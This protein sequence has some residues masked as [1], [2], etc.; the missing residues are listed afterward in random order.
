MSKSPIRSC[1]WMLTV[2][3]LCLSGCADPNAQSEQTAN[4]TLTIGSDVYSPYFYLDDNGSFTGVD[5]EIATEACHRLDM[6][7][8][9]KRIDWQDKDDKLSGG[10]V[11]CLW[12]SF[13]MNGREDQYAW[14]G[15]YMYSRQ[16]VAV[17]A[18]S[19]IYAL[20]D[21]TDKRIAV[22]NSSM[23]E[24][25]FISDSIPNVSVRKVYSFT[26][27]STAFA[28]LR[29]GYVDACAAH[30]AALRDEMSHID[31]EYRILD[32]YL[33]K[34]ELGVAF[35]KDTGTE[36]AK[37]LTAV[38]DEMREDGTMKNILENYDLDVDFALKGGVND[39]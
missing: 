9:F 3:S 21:L 37:K 24:N 6:T 25:L 19:D 34:S 36:Q 8:K 1:L 31:G 29:K 12:G 22:Q 27:V 30:E 16:S 7:P 5:V 17:D 35:D 20:S 28:A 32:A 4:G 39:R 10:A 14:A 13:S 23:P 33:I 38:L 18:S 26:T 11:D 15:P 2:L